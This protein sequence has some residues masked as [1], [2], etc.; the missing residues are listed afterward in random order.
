[1]KKLNFIGKIEKINFD[2]KE[3]M[4]AP[5]TKTIELPSAGP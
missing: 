3:I 1:M 2:I 4:G 5:P